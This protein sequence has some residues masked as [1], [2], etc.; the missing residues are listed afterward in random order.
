MP[1]K[2]RC[3]LLKQTFRFEDD[4]STL[5]TVGSGVIIETKVRTAAPSPGGTGGWVV[6]ETLCSFH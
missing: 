1:G 6:Y 2:Q 5:K 3:H 4:L